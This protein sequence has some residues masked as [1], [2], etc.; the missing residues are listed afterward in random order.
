MAESVYVIAHD[1]G[2]TGCKSCIYRIG[3]RIELVDSSLAEYPLYTTPD[4]GAEQKAEEWWSAL[5]SATRKIVKRSGVSPSRIRAMAFCAQMQGSVFVDGSGRALRN[6]MSYMDGRSGP[7]IA[8]GL[9]RGL[10][11]I[12]KW[13]ARKT[14]RSLV[15][16][17]GLA[18][19]PKDPLWKYHWVRENEPAV[20]ERLHKWLDVKDYLLLR[21]TG[22]YAMTRD[23]AN[24]TFLYDTRP[25]RLGW[26]AGLCDLFGVD[27]EHL[28]PVV[29]STDEVGR[30]LPGPAA[31]M[32]LPGGIP[33]FGGGG[34][35]SMT[36]IGA[37]CLDLHDTHVYVGTSGWIV[38]NV[39]RRMVD[40]G[41]FVASILGAIPGLYSYTAEQETSGACMKWVRD[42]M[43]LDEIGVY[44]KARHVAEK[45][46]EYESLF[47][48]LN[49]VIDGTPPGSGNVIFTPWLHGN[50]SPREDPH[51]RGIFFNLGLGTG[52]GQMI[53][54]VL[55]G[56]AFHKRWMLEAMERKIPRRER[57]RFVGGGALSDAGCRIMADVTGRVIETVE[58]SQ[59]VGAVGAA[60]VCAVGL[61]IIGS[62][63]G[64][65]ALIPVRKEYR[66]NPG[67]RG[68]YDRNFQVFT[69]LYDANKKLFAMLNG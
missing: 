4:G 38:S 41:N 22:E 66:P 7:Q 25:G 62:F 57:L 45:S 2:T 12:G 68:L 14:V 58:D 5:S 33:V 55:E 65:K 10:F 26:H 15:V 13:N 44:L 49:E 24:L 3:K 40:I 67:N 43:A 31:E 59:N 20:F 60:L 6:P 52:K 11:K 53:R 39:D 29:D 19:T 61:G 48:Y 37:G 23:S 16:T 8:R 35:V 34:D 46:R 54:A 36:A 28:P 63:A 64:A 47:D 50:R 1:V 42:H 51:A 17:G 21:C 32:G 56:M 18:A 30:L 27:M 9:Y 69:K